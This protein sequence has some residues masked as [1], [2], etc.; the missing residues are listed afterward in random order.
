MSLDASDGF[1]LRSPAELIMPRYRA[2]ARFAKPVVLA[3]VGLET[4]P[5][6]LDEE[7][8]WLQEFA[9]LVAGPHAPLLR[10]VVYFNAPHNLADYDIDWR[11]ARE[12]IEIMREA[13]VAQARME[14]ASIELVRRP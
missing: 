12:E 14:V 13:W 9:A 7:R 4:H 1:A 6:R 3:E 5:D 10:G 8:R 11:L 2:I